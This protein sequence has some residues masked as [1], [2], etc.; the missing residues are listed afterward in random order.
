MGGIGGGVGGRQGE[1]GRGVRAEGRS[2]VLFK[3]KDW[4]VLASK[5]F[6]WSHFKL[7]KED[8]L[9]KEV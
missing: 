5:S 2:L 1:A 6:I 4:S 7:T 3:E 9:R 8:S